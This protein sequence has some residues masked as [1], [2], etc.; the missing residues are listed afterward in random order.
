MVQTH[1]GIL[2]LINTDTHNIAD[3]QYIQSEKGQITPLSHTKKAVY[4]VIPLIEN[5]TKLIPNDR[6]QP[7][8]CLGI[9]VRKEKMRREG[10]RDYIEAH[11]EIFG[12]GG[13]INYFDWG[14]GFMTLNI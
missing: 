3:Y 7:S 2:L 12:D 9:V 13:Y 11:Q 8:D 10:K 6:K 4:T 14:D 1:N 5:S